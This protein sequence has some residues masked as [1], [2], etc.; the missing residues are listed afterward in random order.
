MA[1]QFRYNPDRD[2]F[3]VTFYDSVTAKEIADI[4]QA[5]V[6]SDHWGDGKRRLVTV[7]PSANLS[8]LTAESL[9]ADLLPVLETLKDKFANRPRIAVIA[10][11]LGTDA[12]VMFYRLVPGVHAAMDMKSCATRQEA[13]NFLDGGGTTPAD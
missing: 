4:M 13:E 3:E 6:A 7:N 1:S 5:M 12:L 2:W 8:L 9:Q 10:H 11:N